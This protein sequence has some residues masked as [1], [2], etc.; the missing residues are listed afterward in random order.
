MDRRP[1]WNLSAQAIVNALTSTYFLNSN[2]I[3]RVYIFVQDLPVR[4]ITDLLKHFTPSQFANMVKENK[5]SVND[6]IV[7]INTPYKSLFMY[8]IDGIR[9]ACDQESW[10]YTD[11]SFLT[12]SQWYLS[13]LRELEEVTG[14]LPDEYSLIFNIISEFSLRRYSQ[15][16]THNEHVASEVD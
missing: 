7:A 15:L 4:F 6:K 10:F 12:H 9:I 16:D 14:F 1:L 8:A 2:A 3:N 5:D 11:Y 13:C